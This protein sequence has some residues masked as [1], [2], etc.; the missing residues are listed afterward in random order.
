[1]IPCLQCKYFMH[2][3]QHQLSQ[4]TL[5]N[6]HVHACGKRTWVEQHA[7][8]CADENTKSWTGLKCSLTPVIDKSKSH[9]IFMFYVILTNSYCLEFWEK[10]WKV[11]C[12]VCYCPGY[13]GNCAICIWITEWPLDIYWGGAEYFAKKD[14]S[15]IFYEIIF[16][17]STQR[18][19]TNFSTQYYYILLYFYSECVVLARARVEMITS[20]NPPLTMMYVAWRRFSVQMLFYIYFY[21]ESSVMKTQ[22]QKLQVG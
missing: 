21:T 19:A 9:W 10:C 5:W 7:L 16:F 3:L 14:S 8:V 11:S 22:Y 13:R 15:D 12:L 18:C 6:L 4:M 2:W 17:V 20:I 1:M